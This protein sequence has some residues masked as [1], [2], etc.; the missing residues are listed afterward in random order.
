MDLVENIDA[1][2]TK[3][4]VYSAAWG[5]SKCYVWTEETL[6]AL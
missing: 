3:T 1:F 6:E 2:S 5:V 4:G